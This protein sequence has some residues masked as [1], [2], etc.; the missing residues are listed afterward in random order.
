[1]TKYLLASAYLIAT[2]YTVHFIRQKAY[3]DKPED[4]TDGIAIGIWA[5][6][7]P[8]VLVLQINKALRKLRGKS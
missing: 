8:V 3:K 4:V 5:L 1:V 7:W 2:C 6:M